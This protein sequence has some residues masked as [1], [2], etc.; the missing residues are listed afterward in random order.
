M[1]KEVRKIG[2]N[3]LCPCGSGKK[4]KACHEGREAELA[5]LLANPGAV[6]APSTAAQI[7][8]KQPTK[9]P[10]AA[11]QPAAPRAQAAPPKASNG[12]AQPVASPTVSTDNGNTKP[13]VQRGRVARGKKR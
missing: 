3:E 8:T 9:A 12:D 13:Q 2:R 6:P 11:T 5:H 4:F 1:R 10:V 7:A